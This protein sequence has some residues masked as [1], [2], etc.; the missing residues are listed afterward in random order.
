LDSVAYVRC[1][2][3]RVSTVTMTIMVLQFHGARHG[4]CRPPSWFHCQCCCSTL[5]PLMCR[6]GNLCVLLSVHRGR[7]SILDWVLCVCACRM[8]NL[9]NC[10]IANLSLGAFNGLGSI[11]Y[12]RSADGKKCDLDLECPLRFFTASGDFKFLLRLPM[13]GALFACRT[14]DLRNNNISSLNSGS[15]T[16]LGNLTCVACDPLPLQC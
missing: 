13:C 1:T 14:L 15:F 8:L 2:V 12:V 5:R 9:T 11:A 4:V 7:D 10:S 6:P 3:C 16:G